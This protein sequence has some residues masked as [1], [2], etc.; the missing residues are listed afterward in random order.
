M[1]S[2][3]YIVGTIERGVV[4]SVPGPYES[5][6]RPADR[7]AERDEVEAYW[8]RPVWNLDPFVFF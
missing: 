3:V 4:V 2:Y 8:K 5:P 7:M 6:L 1:Y